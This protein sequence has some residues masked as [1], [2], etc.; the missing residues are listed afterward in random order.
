MPMLQARDEVQR[1]LLRQHAQDLS[2][3]QQHAEAAEAQLQAASGKEQEACTQL[4]LSQGRVA[5]QE[6]AVHC[7]RKRLARRTQQ[8]KD[9][10]A[11][12]ESRRQ[13][14]QQWHVTGTMQVE[15]LRQRPATAPDHL[16]G[17]SDRQGHADS[18]QRT[19]GG[20]CTCLVMA[21]QRKISCLF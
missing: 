13:Q 6:R 11:A 19:T 17:A 7:L 5:G 8:L 2:Q 20:T 4:R 10:L 1:Q 9:A 3:A 14:Q 21:M 18:C 12:Q 16:E 15:D